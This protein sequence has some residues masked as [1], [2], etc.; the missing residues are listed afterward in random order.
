MVL[1]VLVCLLAAYLKTL[2]MNFDDILEQGR[3]VT[4]NKP[5][6]FGGDA[7]PDVLG[8]FFPLWDRGNV[9]N[10]AHKSVSFQQIS[11]FFFGCCMFL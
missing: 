5:L 2:L 11:D 10:F 1:P 9:T 8:G 6:D 3:C 4:G 7:E